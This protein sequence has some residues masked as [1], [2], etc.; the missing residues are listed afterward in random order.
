MVKGFAITLVIGVIINMFTAIVV[1]RTFLRFVYDAL[2]EKL[3]EKKWLMG[4]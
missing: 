2:G 1:T 4:I 3:R